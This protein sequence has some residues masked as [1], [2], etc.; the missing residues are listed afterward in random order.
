MGDSI[1]LAGFAVDKPVSEP[2][3][4]IQLKLLWRA[5]ARPDKDYTVFVH[6]LDSDGNLVAG[7]DSQPLAG[8]YPTT[9]WSPNEQILDTRRLS[10]PG[11][12]PPG[13]YQLAIGLY[14]QPT[15][16]RLSLHLP[17]GGTVP[18]GRFILGQE[19]TIQ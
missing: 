3:A 19:I 16:R 8:T 10:I 1:Q 9:I 13:Q 18:N 12:L 11:N 14:Y 17:D 5:L 6:L 7:N 4:S 15:G 2:G